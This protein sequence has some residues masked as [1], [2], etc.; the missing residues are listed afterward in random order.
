M[1]E[2][3]GGR[4]RYRGGGGGG[5]GVLCREEEGDAAAM[6]VVLVVVDEDFSAV[7]ALV[8]L[9]LY[10]LRAEFAMIRFHSV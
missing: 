3:A 6:E 8:V 5:A 2:G 7:M 10:N 9:A 4:C 1:E